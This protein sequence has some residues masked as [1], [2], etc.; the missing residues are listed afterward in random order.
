[1]GENICKQ[2]IQ[3]RVNIQNM[4]RTHATQHQTNV[5]I[6]KW[7]EDLNRHFSKK[8]I[9]TANGHMKRSLDITS[10]Q[11][12]AKQNHNEISL[13]TCQNGYC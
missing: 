4:Q 9:Q 6:K 5:L 13:H 10:N 3:E 8:D 1:M 12:N 7:A 11:G 2:Y